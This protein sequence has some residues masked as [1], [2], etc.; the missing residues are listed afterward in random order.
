MDQS[1]GRSRRAYVVVGFVLAILGC[2][3]PIT[4][5]TGITEHQQVVITSASAISLDTTGGIQAGSGNV[6]IIDTSGRIP[7]INDTFFANL[8]TIDFSG[9]T[10]DVTL[11]N[12][13]DALNFDTNTLSLDALN[14]RVGIGTVSP[15]HVLDVLGTSMLFRQVDAS[16]LVYIR[17]AD[18]TIANT[19]ILGRLFFSGDD[20]SAINTPGAEIRARA[21]GAWS[22]GDT[23]GNFGFFTVLDGTETL[24][25]ALT[26]DS[27]QRVGIGTTSPGELVHISKIQASP[28]TLKITNTDA[29]GNVRIELDSATGRN[30]DIT[31]GGNLGFG[32][33]GNDD[34]VHID[35]NG[36]LFINDTANVKCTICLTINQGANDDEAIALKSSDVAHGVTDEAE[37]DTYGTIKKAGFTTGGIRISGYSEDI[38]GI[39]FN[40]VY[41][42]GDTVKTSSAQG[43]IMMN[44]T[45]KSGTGTA[46]ASADHNLFVLRKGASGAVA[47]W[48]VDADGDTFRDGT[49]NTFTDYEDAEMAL[50]FEQLAGGDVD[51]TFHAI[52]RY[53]AESLLDAGIL[54]DW[55]PDTGAYYYNESALLRLAIGAVWQNDAK[56]AGLERRLQE[57]QQER[58]AQ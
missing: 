10:V 37:T 53:N 32:T 1:M 42:N 35:A 40:S 13:V 56:I 57:L 4:A 11:N 29:G 6:G 2:V 20:A 51:E 38:Q 41:T 54:T 23:P 36:A 47:V 8:A 7:A 16:P 45:I 52:T 9:Q 44:V 50:A 46:N 26:I 22:S 12:A 18:T 25:E 21:D 30:N 27:S 49:D 19:A 17:R 3:A 31:A 14:N 34:V 28:T 48:F 5:Q 43:A 24:T 58:I 39:T 33:A 55:D 15:E